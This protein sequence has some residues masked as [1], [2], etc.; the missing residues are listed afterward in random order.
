MNAPRRLTITPDAILAT[1]VKYDE[2][3]NATAP[4]TVLNITGILT[5]DDVATVEV[6]LRI[7]NGHQ[8]STIL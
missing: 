4:K 7:P 6:F 1:K 2:K 5:E 8:P 3:K